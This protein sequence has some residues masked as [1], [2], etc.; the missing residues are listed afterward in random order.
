MTRFTA[1]C[2]AALAICWGTA[3]GLIALGHRLQHPKGDQ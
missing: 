2:F 1:Q 3:A